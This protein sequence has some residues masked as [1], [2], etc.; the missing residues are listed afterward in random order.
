MRL[1]ATTREQEP[2]DLAIDLREDLNGDL[3]LGERRD[4]ADEFALVKVVGD[5]SR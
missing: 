5:A 1:I 4:D 3:L 2:L